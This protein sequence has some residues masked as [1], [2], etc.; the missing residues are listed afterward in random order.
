[1]DKWEYFLILEK[2]VLKQ[3][4]NH[5]PK[6]VQHLYALIVVMFGWLLF[7]Y[8]NMTLLF[9]HLKS[10]F[11]IGSVAFCGVGI[12]YLYSNII[13]FLILIIGA[14]PIPKKLIKSI[15]H[16]KIF[17]VLEILFVLGIWI[18]SI[19]YLVDATYNP[20]LYFRF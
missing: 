12:Y 10:M 9:K 15:Q 2:Y 17:T 3:W 20:F 19:A 8:E 14:T 5:W 11:A 18:L 4:F 6:W 13:L 1:M 16:K 7:A